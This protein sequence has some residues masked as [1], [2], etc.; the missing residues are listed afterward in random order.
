MIGETEPR[1]QKG[2]RPAAS[3]EAENWKRP[4]EDAENRIYKGNYNAEIRICQ[5]VFRISCYDI[6]GR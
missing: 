1:K 4:R 3:A 6:R 2:D 5:A